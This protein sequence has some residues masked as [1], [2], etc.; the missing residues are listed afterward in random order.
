MMVLFKE[1]ASYFNDNITQIGL[2]C[3]NTFTDQG[4]YVF[5]KGKLE[6]TFFPK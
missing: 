2:F 4:L 5:M 6:V 1:Q 3:Q